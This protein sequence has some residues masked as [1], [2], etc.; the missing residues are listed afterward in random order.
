MKICISTCPPAEADRLAETLVQERLA[1]CVN[2]AGPVS[3][4]YWW[5]GAIQCD[6]EAVLIIKTRDDL[7]DRLMHRLGELHPY[8]VPEILAVPV[9]SGSHAYLQ[10]VATE[11]NPGG[12][13][14]AP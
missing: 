1:A 2:I 5:E 8:E 4:R 3:S 11:A 9:E 14:D 13:H 10:W 7:V 12:H 6:Q